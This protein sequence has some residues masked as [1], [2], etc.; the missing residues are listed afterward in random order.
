MR[1]ALTGRYLTVKRQK[2]REK[3]TLAQKAEASA[4]AEVLDA[5][6]AAI[7]ESRRLGAPLQFTVE[8]ETDGAPRIVDRRDALEAAVDLDRS[9]QD[10]LD[11]AL[12]AAL[13]AARARG[14]S[15]V[16]EILAANDMLSAEAF[17][18]HLQTTRATINSKRQAHKVLGLEGATRGFRYPVWQVGE[19]G[20]PFAAM[21]ALFGALGGSAWAV[22]RFLVQTHG[23]LDGLT[24]REALR[25]GRDQDVL[26]AAQS[27]AMAFA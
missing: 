23:E 19:D 2:T 8:V 25:R 9:A 12:D 18:D 17:A 11:A 7:A 13:V 16:A 5:L 3:S 1:D 10:E 6:R 24:G 20:R 26:D 4:E 27:V 22:Y 14:R 21:P 15:R